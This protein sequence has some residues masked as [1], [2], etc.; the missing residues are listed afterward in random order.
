MAHIESFPAVAQA[1][2]RVL[3]LG[4]M[5]GIVSLTQN[6]YYSHKHNLFWRIMGELVGAHRDLPYA[7]RLALLTSHH[8]TL[9]DVMHQCF[10]P[11]SLDSAIE[12]SSIVANDFAV[13]FALHPQIKHVFFNGQKAAKTF[14]RHVIKAE[15]LSEEAK[16]NL[17]FITLPSTSP[18]NAGISYE[19]K[20]EQWKGVKSASFQ[21]QA[22]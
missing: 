15:V 2:A 4:S 3:I 5:P 20:L 1:D 14:Q 18:A 8:I 21:S 10:R 13:F 22:A 12:E 11:G 7:E 6:E 19:I 16:A 17:V 9:W